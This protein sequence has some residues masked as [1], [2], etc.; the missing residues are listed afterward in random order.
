MEFFIKVDHHIIKTT[1]LLAQKVDRRLCRQGARMGVAKPNTVIFEVWQHVNR[2]CLLEDWIP[3]TIISLFITGWFMY[4]HRI[5]MQKG[6]YLLPADAHG[7]TAKYCND[8]SWHKERY[9][10]DT[11][12]QVLYDKFQNLNCCYV[13]TEN[14]LRTFQ[15]KQ[16]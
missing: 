8:M 3:K 9:W 2:S 7:N 5:E 15:K 14:G 6:I 4:W 12:L 11:S 10:I 16:W 13:P 1:K